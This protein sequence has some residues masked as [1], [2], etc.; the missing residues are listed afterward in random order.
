MM[1]TTTTKDCGC[2]DRRSDPARSRRRECIPCEIPPACRNYYYKGKLLTTRDFDQE[3]TYHRDQ[4]RLHQ[5]MLHGWGVAC[6][7]KVSRHPIC[8][9]RHIVVEPGFAVDRC[10]R[11]ARLAGPMN[12]AARDRRR[13]RSPPG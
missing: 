13:T 5:L 7:F 2:H 10:G 11:E 12:P 4:L 1:T 9:D 3:Q 6:G 8:P